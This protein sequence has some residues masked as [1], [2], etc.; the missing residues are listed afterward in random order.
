METLLLPLFVAA[1]VGISIYFQSRRGPAMIVERRV[2]LIWLWLRRIVCF[3]AAALCASFVFV[4]CYAML[5][6]PVTPLSVI[7]ALLFLSLAYVFVHLGMYGMGRALSGVTDDKAVH[8]S[9][10][11]RYGWPW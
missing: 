11:K 10:K 6:S 4:A 2:A 1:L 5:T 7:G 8:E 9:R 3:G